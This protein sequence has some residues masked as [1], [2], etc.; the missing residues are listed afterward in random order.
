MMHLPPPRCGYYLTVASCGTTVLTLKPGLER[1]GAGDS[2]VCLGQWKWLR[3]CV[4]YGSVT[5][6]TAR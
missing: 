4:L 1:S 6:S 3:D 2:R 5:F